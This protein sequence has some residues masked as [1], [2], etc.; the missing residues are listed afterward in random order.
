MSKKKNLGRVVGKSVLSGEPAKLHSF[1]E[2]VIA[3]LTQVEFA[4]FVLAATADAEHS[5]LMKREKELREEHADLMDEIAKLGSNLA[6]DINGLQLQLQAY[7]L[8]A[9]L[10]TTLAA[11][12]KSGLNILQSLKNA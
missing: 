7:E 10:L 9:L 5:A 8:E 11:K 6:S 3:F 4:K 12:A 1:G 2:G